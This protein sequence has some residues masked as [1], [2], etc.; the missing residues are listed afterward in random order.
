MINYE[1]LATEMI[2]FA[3]TKEIGWI[4]YFRSKLND[5]IGV[6][7][8]FSSGQVND[9][10]IEQRINPTK[11]LKKD[12]DPKIEDTIT[13][14]ENGVIRKPEFGI[15]KEAEIASLLDEETIAPQ[16]YIRI[17]PLVNDSCKVEGS[18]TSKTAMFS[19][20]IN[21]VI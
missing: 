16:S 10:I 2:K 19:A 7:Q 6:K 4:D 3:E 21:R 15:L 1:N 13:I 14:T 18:T 9:S 12:I 20:V 5:L 8:E 17:G 11:D